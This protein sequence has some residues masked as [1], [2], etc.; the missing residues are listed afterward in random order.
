MSTLS[1]NPR[2]DTSSDEAS[3]SAEPGAAGQGKGRLRGL[4]RRATPRAKPKVKAKAKPRAKVLPKAAAKVLGCDAYIPTSCESETEPPTGQAVDPDM[5]A[6]KVLDPADAETVALG[7]KQPHSKALCATKGKAKAKVPREAQQKRSKANTM[8]TATK[9]ASSS[10]TQR[11]SSSNMIVARSSATQGPG[12]KVKRKVPEPTSEPEECQP[13]PAPVLP[14]D[15][16]GSSTPRSSGVFDYLDWAVSEVL[17]EAER[18]RLHMDKPIGFGS[19]CAGM[20]T[21]EVVLTRLSE[22]LLRHGVRFEAQ[23]IFRA[24]KEPSK[25]AFLQ[26]HYPSTAAEYYED[27]NALQHAV[28]KNAKGVPVDRPLVGVLLR[29]CAQRHQ[30]AEQQA[31]VREGQRQIRQ[32]P[33]GPAWLHWGLALGAAAKACP[34]GVRTATGAQARSGP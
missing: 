3:P 8:A 21:E 2:H 30:P 24:E 16:T 15:H 9:W 19:M 18:G 5:G 12:A 23:A 29:H 33:P 32:L 20:G 22:A 17:T 27:N 4:A 31:Q 14:S 26:R 1:Q 25:R 28:A 11:T 10:T 6:A 13:L 7:H 34:V